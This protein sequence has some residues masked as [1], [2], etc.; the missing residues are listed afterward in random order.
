[1]CSLLLL[2]KVST[3]QTNSHLADVAL[4]KWL[5][6]SGSKMQSASA[7]A[8]PAMRKLFRGK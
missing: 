1:M 6:V 7:R 8:K 2:S 5:G 3:K 4:Q